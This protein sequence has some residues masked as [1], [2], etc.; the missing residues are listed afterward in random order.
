MTVDTPYKQ[1]QLKVR[2]TYHT[3]QLKQSCKDRTPIGEIHL[4]GNWLV[5][6]GF[7]IDTPVTVEVKKGRII[8]TSK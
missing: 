2:E 4:K 7:A 3:Y 8:V 6:A 5:K 1:R